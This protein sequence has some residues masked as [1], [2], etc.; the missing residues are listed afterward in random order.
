MLKKVMMVM[1]SAVLLLVLLSGCGDTPPE[2][3]DT[4]TTTQTT[5]QAPA[6]EHPFVEVLRDDFIDGNAFLV[7][8]DGEGTPGMLVHGNRNSTD[9]DME[10][11]LLFYLYDGQL[12]SIHAF[13]LMGGFFIT[14]H[15]RIATIVS[16]GGQGLFAMFG[17]ENGQLVKTDRLAFTRGYSYIWNGEEITQERFDEL[18]EQY[19]L[20]LENQ[21]DIWGGPNDNAEILAM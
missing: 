2:N 9:I 12:G 6:G 8:A 5:T 13:D 17:M 3:D 16:A 21:R 1:L 20:D 7:D 11:T 19:G 15:N 14:Q 18:V 4:T 10:E